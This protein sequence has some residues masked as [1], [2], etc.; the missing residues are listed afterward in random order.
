M[1]GKT[2][3]SALFPETEWILIHCLLRPIAYKINFWGPL[4]QEIL[5]KLANCSLIPLSIF[6]MVSILCPEIGTENLPGKQQ[7]T[8]GNQDWGG[9]VRWEEM[10]ECGCQ[11]CAPGW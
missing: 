7:L 8:L 11:E 3:V 1:C 9:H 5:N 6:V 10:E 2:V 4:A